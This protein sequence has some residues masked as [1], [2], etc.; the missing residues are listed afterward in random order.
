MSDALQ[1]SLQKVFDASPYLKGREVSFELVN[2]GESTII[3]RGHVHTYYQK[4]MAQ[5]T[6]R[7]VINRLDVQ[8][9][10]TNDIE[11]RG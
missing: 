6:V 5:E 7:Q 9:V 1:E 4:Q 8:F 10:V 11:V 3:L 2:H